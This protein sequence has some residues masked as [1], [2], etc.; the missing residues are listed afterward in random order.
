MAW[1]AVA[2]SY[3]RSRVQD[4]TREEKRNAE[5]LDRSLS[6]ALRILE[7]LSEDILGELGE[8]IPE[9]NEERHPKAELEHSAS[10]GLRREDQKAMQLIQTL[11][12]ELGVGRSIHQARDL[13]HRRLASLRSLSDAA[14][15]LRRDL[16]KRANA[17]PGRIPESVIV[18]WA[19]E[20]VWNELHP[21]TLPKYLNAYR[22]DVSGF[23]AFLGDVFGILG[24]ARRP[25][26][27]LQA[28]H[29]HRDKHGEP[30]LSVE[31]RV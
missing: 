31:Y 23:G 13:L 17:H 22:D 9:T 5:T 11:E 26:S 28:L 24:I 7:Q 2:P 10:V 19:C 18:C 21:N 29:D 14:A 16:N 30:H 12:Q 20:A 8:R 15:I 4:K 6:E 1:R 27:A 3:L 25:S